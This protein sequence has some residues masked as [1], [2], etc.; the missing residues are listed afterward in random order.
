MLSSSFRR[1]KKKIVCRIVILATIGSDDG[2]LDKTQA[3]TL[4]CGVK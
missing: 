4:M 2:N 3:N 1:K